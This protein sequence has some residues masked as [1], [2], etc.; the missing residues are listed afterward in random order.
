MCN[1]VRPL[2]RKQDYFYVWILSTAGWQGDI[3]ASYSRRQRN[4]STGIERSN[5]P[6]DTY[7]NHI[8]C[9]WM[10]TWG[11]HLIWTILYVYVYLVCTWYGQRNCEG[12]VS[13]RG[14]LS[15]P[16]RGRRQVT[17][18]FSDHFQFNWQLI[19]SLSLSPASASSSSSSTSVSSRYI[20][21]GESR[22][23]EDSGR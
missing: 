10:R 11:A 7:V 1:Y 20:E 13:R 21:P 14:R 18:S 15:W 19:I 16:G 3:P 4:R 6:D 5:V 23:G 9:V 8:V 12:L 17:W 22:W 2:T